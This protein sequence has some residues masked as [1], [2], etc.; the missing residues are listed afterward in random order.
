MYPSSSVCGSF[1]RWQRHCT[2]NDN[3]VAVATVAWPVGLQIAMNAQI[4][5]DK[6][7]KL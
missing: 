6:A 2:G 4:I 3:V 1:G 7:I 5:L